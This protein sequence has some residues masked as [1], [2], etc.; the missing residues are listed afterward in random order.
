M[1]VTAWLFRYK[2][3]AILAMVCGVIAALLGIAAMLL[4]LRKLRRS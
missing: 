4:M 2:K 1:E 3:S